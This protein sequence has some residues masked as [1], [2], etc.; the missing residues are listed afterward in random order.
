MFNWFWYM[1]LFWG[2]FEIRIWVCLFIVF[3]EVILLFVGVYWRWWFVF[4]IIFYIIVWELG[5]LIILR[6]FYCMIIYRDGE[7][8][9][10]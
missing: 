10:E 8:E 7:L 2:Y 4:W 5:Y 6:F 3:I 9:K 1:I